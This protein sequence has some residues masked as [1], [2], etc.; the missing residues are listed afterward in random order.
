LP[1]WISSTNQPA[2]WRSGLQQRRLAEPGLLKRVEPTPGARAIDQYHADVGIGETETSFER[3]DRRT[4]Q[5]LKQ[6]SAM[7]TRITLSAYR[8]LASALL[9]RKRAAME[10]S[11]S[12]VFTDEFYCP[13]EAHQTGEVPGAHYFIGAGTS[14]RW[15]TSFPMMPRPDRR[16]GRSRPHL[17]VNRAGRDEKCLH[18]SCRFQIALPSWFLFAGGN[19]DQ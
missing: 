7:V 19:T 5:A 8:W 12:P 6:Q 3:F 10:R 17:F 9:L 1:L 4:R 18:R 11:T 13:S 16:S 2:I 15:S 14:Q